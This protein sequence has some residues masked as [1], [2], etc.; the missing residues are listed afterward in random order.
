MLPGGAITLHYLLARVSMRPS[1]HPRPLTHASRPPGTQE[2]AVRYQPGGCS[3]AGRAARQLAVEHRC[4]N[5]M[6]AAAPTRRK[7]SHPSR[8]VQGCIL[9]VKRLTASFHRLFFEFLAEA[10]RHRAG[11]CAGSGTALWYHHYGKAVSQLSPSGLQMLDDMVLAS[12]F[13]LIRRHR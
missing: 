12:G 4:H 6:T 7:L 1:R 10:M 13:T 3:A 5:S 8:N 9:T 2:R 11:D